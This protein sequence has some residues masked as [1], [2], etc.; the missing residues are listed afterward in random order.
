LSRSIN[1][2]TPAGDLTVIDTLGTAPAAV[3]DTSIDRLAVPLRIRNALKN[4]G[5]RTVRD[6]A[7]VGISGLFRVNGL[8]DLSIALLA[9][10]LREEIERPH[11]STFSEARAVASPEIVTSTGPITDA[12]PSAAGSSVPLHSQLA[13]TLASLDQRDVEVFRRRMGYDGPPENLEEIGAQFGVTRERVRQR[14][15]RALK[16]ITETA[17]W[18]SVASARISQLFVGRAEPL[19]IDLLAVEDR[20]FDGFEDHLFFLGRILETFCGE[21][22]YAWPLKGRLVLA[23]ISQDQ[24]DGLVSGAMS[25]LT[26]A[27]PMTEQDVKLY[28]ES[29]ASKAGA[30]ELAAEL[31]VALKKQI[32][33]AR[34]G[35]GPD[36]M[37]SVGGGQ[38][39]VLAAILKDAQRPLPLREIIKRYTERTGRR[40]NQNNCRGALRALGAC[41]VARGTFSLPEYLSLA[42]GDAERVVAATESIIQRGTPGRQ[43]HCAEL[44]RELKREAIRVPEAI[45]AYVLNALLS[46]SQSLRSL[47]RLVW[48][49]RSVKIRRREIE[50]LCVAVLRKAGRPLLTSEMRAAVEKVRGLNRGFQP[51]PNEVMTRV[52]RGL[53]VLVERDIPLSKTEREKVL[54]TLARVLHTR[55]RPLHLE[56]LTAALAAAGCR[57]KK[58]VTPEM[59]AGLAFA[60]DRFRSLRGDHLRLAHG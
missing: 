33:F 12:P 4:K 14:E 17:R 30:A 28:L 16:R 7:A 2:T 22:I 36:V 42:P 45:N 29:M 48:A 25:A 39:G 21:S 23:R 55:R 41:L 32:H 47:K 59:I 15:S 5:F 37:V 57:V 53:W 8:G 46:R 49:T 50:D 52:G 60:D 44:L 40:I 27:A 1:L 34:Q 31:F 18:P 56:D 38:R 58:G 9:A 11:T 10:C 43:W 26:S 35:P 54:E 19:H 20:W 13:T 6:I 3:L 51:H 24:W